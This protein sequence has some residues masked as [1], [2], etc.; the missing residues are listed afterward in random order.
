MG[1]IVLFFNNDGF[2]IINPLTLH[3]IKQRNKI[4]CFKIHRIP[5]VFSFYISDEMRKKKI[6][7]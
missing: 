6:E 7:Y 3:A 4:K 2:G 5:L 1:E